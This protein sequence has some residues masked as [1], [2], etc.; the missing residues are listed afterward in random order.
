MGNDGGNTMREGNLV[1]APRDYLIGPVFAATKQ[2]GPRDIT[3]GKR[4]YQVG[5][6]HPMRPD[7]HP[8]ALDVRHARAIFT[9][10]SFRQ[11]GDRTQLIRFSFNEFCRRYAKSNGGRYARAIKSVVADLMDAY[12]RVTDLETDVEHEYRLIEHIDTEKR[13]PRRKDARAA[14]S[15]QRELWFNGCTLSP[16]FAGLL[17]QISELQFL[18]LDVLTSIRSPLAQAIYLYIPSRAHHHSEQQPFQ[19]TVTNLLQQVSYPVPKHKSRRLQIFTQRAQTHTSVIQ[20]L[21]GLETLKGIFRLRLI[22]NE[23]G[24]DWKLLAWTEKERCKQKSLPGNSKL[25]AAW[26]D[27]G[28]SLAVL[29]KRLATVPPLTPYEEE[30]LERAAVQ[31]AGNERFFALAKAMLPP[32]QF[33]GL[34]AEAKGDELEGR[35]ATKNP[36][37]RLI[38]RIKSAISAPRSNPWSRPEALDNQGKA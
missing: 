34:L 25:I 1:A 27:S 12:I 5:G 31:V 23:D 16:E 29:K 26:L 17:E 22:E 9:L 6:F 4:R 15:P 19:I 11:P 24:T 21:D 30:L 33:V 35:T 14:T 3:I 38:W 8:P 20:Q 7:F 37:A 32:A 13:A 2:S 36:T 28:R 10:L 18:K